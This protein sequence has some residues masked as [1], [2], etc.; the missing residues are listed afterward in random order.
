MALAGTLMLRT[1]EDA[2]CECSISGRYCVP[3]VDP[4]K[5]KAQQFDIRFFLQKQV[6]AAL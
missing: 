6:K 5:C 1:G 2:M 4:E 3:V